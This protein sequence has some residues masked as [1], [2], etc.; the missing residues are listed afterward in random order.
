M[1]ELFYVLLFLSV[2]KKHRQAAGQGNDQS[3]PMRTL[4]A[5]IE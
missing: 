4:R 5:I 1:D 2:A 3:R